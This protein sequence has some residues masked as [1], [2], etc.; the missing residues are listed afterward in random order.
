MPVAQELTLYALRCPWQELVA[1]LAHTSGA[2]VETTGGG[3]LG[4]V[5]DLS[6]KV[7]P[8]S[9]PAAAYTVTCSLRNATSGAVL[10]QTTHTVTRVDDNAPQPTA[11]I[12][13]HQRLIHNGKPKFVIG[14]YMSW[15]P[16]DPGDPG[17]STPAEDI[18]MVGNS[19]FNTIMPYEAP[20]NETLLD[21]ISSAG[22]QVLFSTKDTY[23]MNNSE[24]F[25][26]AQ[27]AQWKDHEAVLGWC[28]LH[29]ARQ[30]G[31]LTENRLCFPMHA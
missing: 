14:L 11:W 12:D 3:A 26:K 19:S 25:V 7:V 13:E 15:I 1:T 24:A 10:H 22:L 6:F 2:V 31:P 18:L 29:L 28:L 8:D 30:S 4:P 27:V 17:W 20:A 21:L 23:S 9:L 5:V 16:H